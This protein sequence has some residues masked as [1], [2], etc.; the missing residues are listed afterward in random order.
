MATLTKLGPADFEDIKAL[1]KSVFT[2]P[3]W[4]DD[5]SDDEQLNHYLKDLMGT[6]TPLVLGL[7]EG[8]ELVGLS[9][10]NIKHWCEGTEYFIEEFCIRTDLQGRGL[11][12]QFLSLIEAH[13][14]ER[15]LHQIF[16]MTER[17]VP[18]YGFY[19]RRGFTELPK[20]VAFFKE[21]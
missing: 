19:Q 9:I 16:L 3:P 21:F 7:V 8:G 12:S 4:N 15:G 1:F 10:G 14:K 20:N 2:R 6:R 13:L 18:A 5:W 17:D 11:G